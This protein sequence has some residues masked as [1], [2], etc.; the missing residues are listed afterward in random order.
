MS[1]VKIDVPFV[2][3][4]NSMKPSKARDDDVGYDLH[5]SEDI[6]IPSIP[7]AV[8][9]W[10][11]SLINSFLNFLPT[12]EKPSTEPPEL[13][14]TKVKT[15][16]G[17]SIPKGHF[18]LICD[19][20]GMGSKA[21]KVMGGVIDASYTGELLVC[22]INLSFKDYE[23]KKEAKI[24]QIL[25]IPYINMG[26]YEVDELEPSDRGAAGFGSSGV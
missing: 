20:S 17:L 16:I 22:L 18:G 24:A 23:I 4:G 26:L 7:K 11:I 8:G 19:R 5:A 13:F 3:F 2:R 15:N 1:V 10:V 12:K 14:G 9:L 6:I 25:I 21:I